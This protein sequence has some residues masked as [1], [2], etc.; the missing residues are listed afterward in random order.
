MS[1]GT[2]KGL[3]GL[4]G[5]WE[6]GTAPSIPRALDRAPFPSVKQRLLKL[7]RLFKPE[8]LSLLKNLLFPSH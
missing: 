3:R 4:W 8:L 6:A 1:P 5:L 2:A 7:W